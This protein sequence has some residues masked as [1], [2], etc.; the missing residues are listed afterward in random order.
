M[1]NENIN[2]KEYYNSL[3]LILKKVKSEPNA[4]GFL[5]PVDYKKYG[6]VDY[7]KIIKQ[8]MDLKTIEYK[9]NNYEYNDEINF[10]YDLQLIWDNCK[11]YNMEGSLIFQQ[12]EEME[13]KCDTYLREYFQLPKKSKINFFNNRKY[14]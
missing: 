6:L 1:N 9:L 13:R 8:P 12:A 7:L 3:K 5:E 4:I 14:V 2:Y 10:I 11:K